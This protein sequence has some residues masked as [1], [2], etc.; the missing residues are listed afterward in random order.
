MTFRAPVCVRVCVCVCV[1]VCFFLFVHRLAQGQ[2]F[3]FD[4]VLGGLTVFPNVIASVNSSG[5]KQHRAKP[6]APPTPEIPHVQ[7]LPRL[8]QS[9]VNPNRHA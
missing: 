1:C 3:L 6:S 5:A 9:D 8:C 2:V 7:L 4:G